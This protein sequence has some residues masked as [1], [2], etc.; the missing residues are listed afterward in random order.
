MIYKSTG[1]IRAIQ[2]WLGHLKIENTDRVESLCNLIEIYR[3]TT[4]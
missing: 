2:I 3:S 4:K 1:N